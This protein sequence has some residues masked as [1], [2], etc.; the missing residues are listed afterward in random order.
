MKKKGL[1]RT[2]LALAILL[3]SMCAWSGYTAY[4]TYVELPDLLKLC[5]V[6][7]LMERNSNLYF[8]PDMIKQAEEYGNTKGYFEHRLE[9]HYPM[10]REYCMNATPQAFPNNMDYA[11][12]DK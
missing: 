1:K 11:E 5:G 12:A 9:E 4:N 10:L 6:A 3:A 7:V 8:G 2:V